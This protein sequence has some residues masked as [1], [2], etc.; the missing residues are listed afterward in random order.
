MPIAVLCVEKTCRH[1][2]ID[3][4]FNFVT[5]KYPNLDSSILGKLDSV[6]HIVL[7]SIFDGSG[8]KEFEVNLNLSIHLG[9]HFFSILK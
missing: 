1:S 7:E 5:S 4:C 6:R 2:N 3:G 9:N 8:S